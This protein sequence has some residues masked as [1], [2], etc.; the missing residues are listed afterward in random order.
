MDIAP[1]SR[2]AIEIVA[3]PRN[4][5]VYKT[6][7]RLCSK[8]PGVV[9]INRWRHEHR[10]SQQRWRRGG[11]MWHHQMRSKPAVRI[12]PGARYTVLASVDVLRDLASVQRH[13]RLTPA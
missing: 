3:P 10:P 6:L 1:G 7:V 13:V 5:A 2:V 9:R 8:D 11:K 12:A 4:A